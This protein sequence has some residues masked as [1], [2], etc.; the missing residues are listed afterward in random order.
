MYKPKAL[1][2]FYKAEK[3]HNQGKIT[4]CILEYKKAIKIE[5]NFFEAYNN[6]GNAL[7]LSNRLQEAVDNYK[8]TLQINPSLP[9]T[10][11]NLA[12]TLSEL[13]QFKEALEFYD[14]AISLDPTQEK[15]YLQRS[16][17]YY[18]SNSFQN[19]LIDIDRYLSSSPNDVSAQL[20]KGNVLKKLE[21]YEEALKSY[22]LCISLNPRIAK[23][24]L[25]HG[26]TLRKLEQY[27]TALDSYSKALELHP[28]DAYAL[29]ARG[30]LLREIDKYDDGIAD[31]KRA[32]E[33]NPESPEA[34]SFI[35][36]IYSELGCDSKAIYHFRAAL[37]LSENYA[38]A[39]HILSL[40]LLG[41]GDFPEGWKKYSY[42]NKV[43]N[44][45]VNLISIKE[46]QHWDGDL[47]TNQ[48]LLIHGEQGI[49]D[50]ILYGNLLHL[51]KLNQISH[52]I[53]VTCDKR[54]IPIYERTHPEF[55]FIS[56]SDL[57]Y[58]KWKSQI[59]IGS[60]GIHLLKDYSDFGKLKH[61]NL[62]TNKSLSI[63][64]A[65]RIKKSAKKICGISWKSQKSSNN[66]GHYKS[67]SLVDLLPILKKDD[68][69][70]VNLQYGNVSEELE[71]LTRD[72]GIKIIN[73]EDIDNFNDIDSLLSL[74]DACDLVITV[75]NVTAHLAGSI[76]KPTYL[77]SPDKKGKFW[78]WKN[79]NEK[80]H[81]LWYPS[82][83]IID[84]GD[85]T[86]WV[87]AV[88]EV[89]DLM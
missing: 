16:L 40:I 26:N 52:D 78:Y 1:K 79:R 69:I 13:K 41:Q 31:L 4:A 72:T 58:I 5:M 3:L 15:P 74:I 47:S 67:I 18:Y 46:N 89:A 42:R 7:R 44:N 21:R 70:F 62:V 66:T 8:K 65:K 6:L 51:L 60:L 17:S 2:L 68:Y 12:N 80:N 19:S 25:N 32:L 28:N 45:P 82:I 77:I 29:I 34:H 35:G 56:A 54:L 63:S 75:S 10:A 38:E 22:E 23:F 57:K 55:S 20:H 14:H 30:S 39:N 87:R 84:Q 48:S 43:S 36:H 33:I 49:G 50:E 64:L 86:D 76:D 73:L 11:L 85:N 53:T 88:T 37:S 81:S 71:K 61:P 24:Y 9:V 83:Q 59:H 27:S